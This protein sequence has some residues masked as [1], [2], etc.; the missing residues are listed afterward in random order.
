M[1]D[2]FN[3]QG[4][5]QSSPLIGTLSAQQTITAPIAEVVQ[6]TNREVGQYTLNADAATPVNFGGLSRAH[7]VIVKV[8]GAGITLRLTSAA[9]TQQLIPVDSF[10]VQIT[11]TTPITAIDLIRSPGVQTLVNTFLGQRD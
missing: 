6:L 4:S 7:V 10:F 9:G 1:A 5:Y 2:T 3:L 11:Q 8:V